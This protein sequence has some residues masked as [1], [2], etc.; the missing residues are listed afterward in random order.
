MKVFV[1]YGTVLDVENFQWEAGGEGQYLNPNKTMDQ[2]FLE[3]GNSMVGQLPTVENPSNGSELKVR[4]CLDLAEMKDDIDLERVPA[5]LDLTVIP[6]VLETS[7]C[8]SNPTPSPK[9]TFCGKDETSNGT[10][11][12]C[13]EQDHPVVQ[14]TY[15]PDHP[16]TSE[17]ASRNMTTIYLFTIGLF[18]FM[19]LFFACIIYCIQSY[20][21]K[22]KSLMLQSGSYNMEPFER[23][24]LTVIREVS[25]P[26][27]TM[28]NTMVPGD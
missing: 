12:T 25:E 6:N 10:Q 22:S 20:Q 9:I 8:Q 24:N 27:H 14:V 17:P 18:V 11:P 7:G 3:S 5:I 21:K 15:D 26:A 13:T 2:I 1:N 4:M 19:V 23:R 16:P 28:T